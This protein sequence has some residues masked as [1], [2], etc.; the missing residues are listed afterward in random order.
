MEYLDRTTHHRVVLQMDVQDI[1]LIRTIAETGTLS[2]TSE[3][4]H[5][6]QP[7]LSK[8]L[9]RL[10][11]ILG[12]ELFHRYPRGL[13]PTDIALYILSKAEPLRAQISE[14]E[15]NVEL[16][17]QLERG[18]LS[19]GVGPIVEQTIL[20]DVLTRFV[21]STGMV[22]LT[23]LTE[24]ENT[25]LEMFTASELDVIVGPFSPEEHAAT[26]R[27]AIPMISDKIIAVARPEHPVF[28]HAAEGKP[29]IQDYQWVAPR[30]QGTVERLDNHPALSQMKVLTENYAV[31]RMLT[32]ATDVICAGPRAVFVEEVKAGNLREVAFPMELTWKSALLIKPETYATPLAKQLVG[33]FEASAN[34]FRSGQ[35]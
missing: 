15:R 20:P 35:R 29:E 16:M 27:I 1:E 26:D 11:Q 4:L 2:H 34:S 25:L 31:L 24:D 33:L 23:I 5:M 13:A 14:I 28:K 9:A 17:T 12:T 22:E 18:H 19:L 10:E 3:K 32:A 8:R 7:T 21:E 6:S 30:T